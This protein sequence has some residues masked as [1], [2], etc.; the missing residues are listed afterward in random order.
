MDEQWFSSDFWGRNAQQGVE[1][2]LSTVPAVILLVVLAY[3]ALRVITFAIGRLKALMLIQLH[4]R[5]SELDVIEVEKRVETLAS[6]LH[7]LAR[8]AV[9]AV[10]IMA[11]LRRLGVDIAPLLAGAGIAGLAIG[12][13]AQELVRDVISGFFMLLEDR[14]RAGDLVV[15]NTVSGLVEKIDLRTIVIRDVTGT[16]HVFQ[17]GKIN[18][19]ANTTKDWSAAVVD[20]RVSFKTDIDQVFEIMRQTAAGLR[21][22][23]VFG[24]MIIADFE[25]FGVEALDAAVTI[26]SRFKSKPMRQREVGGELRKRLKAAFDTAGIELR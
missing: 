7:S 5:S 11:L 22:D 6:I 26:R 10:F 14:V 23:A 21:S 25:I 13:G 15:V 16:V 3:V 12:F 19:L 17:N 20:V 4:G 8:V 18:T 1:W 24:P 2:L 9:W